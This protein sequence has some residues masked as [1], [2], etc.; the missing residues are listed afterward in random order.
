MLGSISVPAQD[1]GIQSVVW[2]GGVVTVTVDSDTDSYYVLQ[3]APEVTGEFAAVAIDLGG[4]VSTL[5]SAVPP[6]SLPRYLYHVVRNAQI[7][8][9]DTDGD[10][11]DDVFELHLPDVLDALDPND[12]GED[13]DDDTVSN[14][15]EFQRGTDLTNPSS[16]NTS[17]CANADT[18]DDGFD[19]L[20]PAPGNGHGPKQTVQSALDESVSGDDIH[21]AG[22]GSPYAEPVWDPGDKAL[23]LIPG[24]HVILQ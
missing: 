6:V 13:A 5:L 21:I 3:G 18:G 12:A 22:D 1:F 16:V 23:T 15:R 17:L 24:G 8:P 2:T 10:G 11:I 9:L 4:P 19:G 20:S 14:L 7:T